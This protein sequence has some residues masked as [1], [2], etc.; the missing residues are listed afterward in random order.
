MVDMAATVDVVFNTHGNPSTML[1]VG[2][3][4]MPLYAYRWMIAHVT[5]ERDLFVTESNSWVDKGRNRSMS[6][7]SLA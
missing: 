6:A 2:G 7:Q 5:L 1:L 4:A 3:S